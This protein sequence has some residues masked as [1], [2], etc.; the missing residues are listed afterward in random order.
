MVANQQITEGRLEDISDQTQHVNRTVLLGKRNAEPGVPAWIG[1]SFVGRENAERAYQFLLERGYTKEEISLVMSEETRKQYFAMNK[2]DESLF[3]AKA[4]ESSKNKVIE[5][6][7]KGI[8]IGTILAFAAN[9]IVPGIGL[10]VGGPLFIGIGAMAGGLSGALIE[11][12]IPAD[13]AKAFES[14][15]KE[16]RILIGVAPRS[17]EDAEFLE[18]EWS[19]L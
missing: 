8:M 15:V 14:D 18:R 16:G 17:V 3:G 9:L 4:I 13:Q 12:G 11:K 6:G 2:E 5:D 10:L 7:N 1:G 19:H